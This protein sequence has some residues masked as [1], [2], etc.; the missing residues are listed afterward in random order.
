MVTAVNLTARSRDTM[1]RAAERFPHQ[2]GYVLSD[3]L[4]EDGSTIKKEDG[5]RLLLEYWD[6]IGSI[7]ILTARARDTRLTAKERP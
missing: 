7:Y 3:L 4:Q 2:D 1:L 6:S 5:D